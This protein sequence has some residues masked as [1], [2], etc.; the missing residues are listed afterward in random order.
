[1]IF[2]KSLIDHRSSRYIF[3]K[4]LGPSLHT[5]LC[6]SFLD[7]F[8][9]GP[10]VL[11]EFIISAAATI[12]R[13]KTAAFTEGL[14]SLSEFSSLDESILTKAMEE[15]DDGNDDGLQSQRT[16]VAITEAVRKTAI[17]KIQNWS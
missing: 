7:G 4:L 2:S 9:F 12:R 1:M 3:Q 8:V 6:Q 17:S 5:C 10:I 15:K 13:R 11:D 14:V 16:G